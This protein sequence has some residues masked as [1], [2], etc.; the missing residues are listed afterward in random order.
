[1]A[2]VGEKV[3]SLKLQQHYVVNKMQEMLLDAPPTILLQ[4][5]VKNNIEFT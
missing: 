5:N 3:R 1:M 4:R 2:V